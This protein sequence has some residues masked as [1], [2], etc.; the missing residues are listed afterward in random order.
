MAE[1]RSTPAQL[2]ERLRSGDRRFSKLEARMNQMEAQVRGHLERQDAHLRQQ[3]EHLRS[4]DEK[5]DTVVANTQSMVETW[6][7]GQKVMRSLCRM[8]DAWRF[9]MRNVVGQL[10]AVTLVAIVIYRYL[11]HEPVPDWAHAAFTFLLG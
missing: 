11:H 6:Q 4:Q 2:E 3:D 1:N 9:L 8:A 7:G 5:L 10:A